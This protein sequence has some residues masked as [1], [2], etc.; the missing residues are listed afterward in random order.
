MKDKKGT[1]TSMMILAVAAIVL[2][3]LVGW[4]VWDQQQEETP[5]TIGGQSQTETGVITTTAKV[6]CP[7]DGTTDGQVRYEDGLATTTTYGST[8][9][10]FV[11]KSASEERVKTGALSTTGA[12][13]TAVD[14]K[15]TES[16]TKWR[17]V[18]LSNATTDVM[19]LDEGTD[20]TAEGAFTKRDVLGKKSD[21]MQFKVEDLFSGAS[22]FFNVSN[23]SKYCAGMGESVMTNGEWYEFNYS[24]TWTNN[25]WCN[26]TKYATT[27]GTPSNAIIIGTDGYIDS[28]IYLKTN[29]TKR[30]F[31]E[32]GLRVWML[33]DAD[34][35]AWDEPVVFRDG[36]ATLINKWSEM[37]DSDKKY[38]SN[39]EYAYEIGPVGDR[40]TTI[41][42]YLQTASGVNPD[43][44]DEP[45][46]EFCA[47]GRYNSAK[48]K[49]TV[50][51]GCWN[52]AT[53]QLVVVHD[54]RPAIG[55]GV[56]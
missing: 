2:V 28:K 34:A 20:W 27:K 55:F 18:C 41:N 33:V 38:Y 4:Y 53:T 47:E 51:I 11:P 3:G 56:Q 22:K 8:D 16:G 10:Y 23:N 48:E 35:D 54:M 12:Y 25:S 40:E 29:N 49:D 45:I 37:Y 6:S 44:G 39:F 7:S 32:D 24:T 36:G 5:L 19:S 17:T 42:F 26:I 31:G 9:C 30:Q 46:I 21:N 52:D 13:S 14:L 1:G 50:L 43:G 15:C